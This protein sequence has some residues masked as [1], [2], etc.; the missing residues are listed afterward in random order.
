MLISIVNRSAKIS[1]AELQCVIRAINR[2]I[3]EDFQPYWSFGGQLRLE[4][5]VGR[6]PD[7]QR[8]LE[9][10]GDAVLYLWDKVD[11]EDALGYHDKNSYGIPYGFV[12]TELAAKLKEPWSVTLSHEALELIGDAQGNL[13]VQG[14][15]PEH[16]EVEVFHWF[17]MCDA[18]QSQT[19]RID[20]VEVADFLL[21]LYFTPN[22]QKGGRNDFLGILDKRGKPLK[23]FGV[24][25]GGYI[26][27]YDPRQSTHTTYSHLDDARAQERQ[28][29][30]A[31]NLFGRGYLRAHAEAVEAREKIQRRV[32]SSQKPSIA[33]VKAAGSAGTGADNIEHVVV[34][35]LENRSFDH[36][37]G[38]MTRIN[39]AVEGVKPKG[40]KPYY[41]EKPD[42]GRIEQ[43]PVAKYVVANKRD[44]DHE[45]DA[46][47][48]QIG[49]TG[50]P[51]SGFV[52]SYVKRYPDAS[53]AE[54]EQVMG[55]FP[56]GSSP[57]D[58]ALP[59][60]HTLARNF[61]VCDHWFSSMPGP[62]WQNRFFAHSATCLG[63]VLMP[64]RDEPQNMRWYY[65]ETIY[66]RLSDAGKDW[67]IYYHGVPQSVV[68]TRMLPD[69][70]TGRGYDD[71]Q[72]F[73]AQAAG[74]PNEFPRYT[75]IEPCYFGA[76]ENDQHPPADVR[77]GEALIAQV[78]NALRANEALWQSTLLVVTYDEHGGFFDHV[79]P[80]ATVAP[81]EY[82]AEWSFD[83]LGVR[84]PAILVSPWVERGVINTVFDH[85]SILRYLCEKWDMPPLGLRMQASAG[86]NRCN[87][88]GLELRK[89]QKPRGDT[90]KSIDVPQIKAAKIAA[91]EP[92]IEGSREALLMY[93]DQLPEPA[94]VPSP[95]GLKAAKSPGKR[96][97][98]KKAPIAAPANLSHAEALAKLA[99]LRGTRLSG[100]KASP[101]RS[102]R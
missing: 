30:K 85:T 26:G 35:M 2:Q 32:L 23:S 7:K 25:D 46:A 6:N 27:F 102:V 97:P 56:F 80:P 71:M 96:G 17:E 4:G 78:Y 93:V 43:K 64:S 69:F 74:D 16:P 67:K 42:G 54:L 82:I 39:R 9:L 12:F 33:P 15:H 31:N 3:A 14:P 24:A 73:F 84:V 88:F 58:D 66:D 40:D 100:M 86:A 47:L 89:L 61:A 52:K 87:T 75:F 63:H 1:D 55:Y 21:P 60:L 38:G 51:M 22:E 91:A 28:R 101:K 34:L 79:T 81:D 92:P 37:L 83:R 18:V 53:D 50:S 77:Q 49:N 48:E 59:V 13:L 98:G 8:L 70:I 95:V 44:L 5:K 10:R 57:Q 45:H 94:S 99:R 20:N 90:P 11:M 19:Y 76:E 65:Q 36:M 72:Q 62:T 41:N 68:M 29:T